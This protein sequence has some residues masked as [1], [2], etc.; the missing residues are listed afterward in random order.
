M[1][2]QNRS[3]NKLKYNMK[4]VLKAFRKKQQ[5]YHKDKC[6]KVIRYNCM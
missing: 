6:L 1:S 5:R 4:T 3:K 2:V